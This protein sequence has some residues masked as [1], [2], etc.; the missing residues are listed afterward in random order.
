MKI[1][2]KTPTSITEGQACARQPHMCRSSFFSST[3]ATENEPQLSELHLEHS[4]CDSASLTV[5]N[6]SR[7][8]DDDPTLR[9]TFQYG[10]FVLVYSRR[11]FI[12]D[13]CQSAKRAYLQLM[14]GWIKWIR[15]KWVNKLRDDCL[16]KSVSKLN[17][18]TNLLKVTFRYRTLPIPSDLT[19]EGRAS[20]DASNAPRL[21]D[22]YSQIPPMIPSPNRPQS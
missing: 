2:D 1:A 10:T 14:R 3:A 20:R 18:G 15:E 11:A 8:H 21:S 13:S 5:V 17:Q 16:C 9:N 7:I 4:I 6:C 19:T 12:N 22:A